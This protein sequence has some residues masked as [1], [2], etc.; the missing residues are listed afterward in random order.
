[1]HPNDYFLTPLMELLQYYRNSEKYLEDIKSNPS[2]YGLNTCAATATLLV[3]NGVQTYEG[4][5][6]LL[7]YQV[8]ET[9]N[10]DVIEIVYINGTSYNNQAKAIIKETGRYLIHT[11]CR[12]IKNVE[13]TCYL[14]GT[15]FAF[16]G[17]KEIDL[18]EGTEITC[19]MPSGYDF[20]G[21]AVMI[22]K[23]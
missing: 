23:L 14:D 12:G 10:S 5:A 19:S 6:S 16:S 22:T 11:M 21:G 1:M 20:R 15:T 13:L 18:E 2:K 7:G 8:G 3:V 17:Q 4:G 9:T